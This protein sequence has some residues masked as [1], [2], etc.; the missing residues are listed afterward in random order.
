MIDFSQW[1]LD[2]VR[3]EYSNMQWIEERRFEWTPL[4]KN[5]VNNISNGFTYIIISDDSKNWLVEYLSQTLN[6][7]ANTSRPFLPFIDGNKIYSKFVVDIKDSEGIELFEDM[8][9]LSYS[10]GYAFFYVGKGSSAMATIAKRNNNS[11]IWITDE[12]IPNSFELDSED[13]YM[14][15]KLV[16]LSNLFNQSIDCLLFET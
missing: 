10:S 5:V 2:K 12:S 15:T 4:V 8:L 13:E 16:Q 11:F 6:K 9:S 14:D 1:T 7:T 3:D